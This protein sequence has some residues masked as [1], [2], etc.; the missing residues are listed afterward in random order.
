M[1]EIPTYCA[2]GLNP[3]VLIRSA[4]IE[5]TLDAVIT[6]PKSRKLAIGD[7]I[8][9]VFE[10]HKLVCTPRPAKGDVLSSVETNEYALATFGV[11]ARWVPVE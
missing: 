9:L 1:R 10:D 5:P 6:G 8:A 2:Y 7:A 3:Q 11:Y 4:W